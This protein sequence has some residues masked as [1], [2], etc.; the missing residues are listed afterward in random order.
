MQAQVDLKAV[1]QGPVSVDSDDVP[2]T[3][4]IL[5]FSHL[6]RATHRVYLAESMMA[7]ALGDQQPKSSRDRCRADF[8]GKHLATVK[9]IGLKANEITFETLLRSDAP[10]EV[11]GTCYEL[12]P[13]VWIFNPWRGWRKR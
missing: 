10:D 3:S 11:N 6:V 7:E 2:V 5:S 1:V 4:A 13:S 12:L 8:Y 9:R